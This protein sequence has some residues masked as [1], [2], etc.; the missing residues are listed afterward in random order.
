MSLAIHNKQGKTIPIDELM[1]E[2]T[3]DYFHRHLIH[4]KREDSFSPINVQKCLPTELRLENIIHSYLKLSDERVTPG[5]LN[6]KS[7]DL[8]AR[9]DLEN[10]MRSHI[11]VHDGSSE[12]SGITYSDNTPE[13]ITNFEFAFNLAKKSNDKNN[14]YLIYDRNHDIYRWVSEHNTDIETIPQGVWKWNCVR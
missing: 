1:I 7:I 2:I 3:T 11:R 12:K 5:A 6:I 10:W 9:N 13:E 14:A 8:S 4:G